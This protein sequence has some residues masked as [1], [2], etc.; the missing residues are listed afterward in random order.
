MKGYITVVTRSDDETYRANVIDIPTCEVA[1]AT[2]AE[3][4]AGAQAS[5]RRL[6]EDGEDL[7]PPRSSVHMF[8]EVSRRKGVAG[9]CLRGNRAAA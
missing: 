2:V 1:G 9:A 8:G 4:L 5:L 3:A 7:P 6:S